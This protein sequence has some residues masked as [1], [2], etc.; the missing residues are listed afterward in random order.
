MTPGANGHASLYVQTVGIHMSVIASSLAKPKTCTYK[1]LERPR[2]PPSRKA[3]GIRRTKLRLS[4]ALG[5]SRR[6]LPSPNHACTL[7][8]G[9]CRPTRQIGC[10]H[11]PSQAD[12]VALAL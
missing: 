11:F 1:I 4:A 3:A 7:V 5:K 6:A 9:A 2:G 12:T 10:R 8:E